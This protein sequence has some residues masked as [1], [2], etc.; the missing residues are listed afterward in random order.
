MKVARTMDAVPARGRRPWLPS[1]RAW[2]AWASFAI[3]YRPQSI[4][5]EAPW[6]VATGA[7]VFALIVARTPSAW[8]TVRGEEG[9][10][11]LDSAINHGFRSFGHFYSGY[12]DTVPRIG[13]AVAAALPL[14]WAA[15]VTATFTVLI[16][17]ICA[18][19]VVVLSGTHL[20]S[21]WVRVGLGLSFALL[22]ASR[23]PSIS[24]IQCLQFPMTFTVFWVLLWR[25]RRWAGQAFGVV[26]VVLA[27][28]SSLL[29]L[30]LAPLALARLLVRKGW[31]IGGS[32][33]G[34]LAF[35]ELLILVFRPKRVLQS[36]T[37]GLAVKGYGFDVLRSQLFGGP[38]NGAAR[39]AIHFEWWIVALILLVVGAV[40]AILVST[41]A[42][43]RSHYVALI[44]TALVAS[45]V[46]FVGETLES[47][48]DARYA[49]VP[50][51]LLT[52]AVAAAT[53]C[54]GRLSRRW[55]SNV[56]Q[57]LFVVA[58]VIPWIWSFSVGPNFANGPRWT[59]SISA[60]KRQCAALGKAA[61]VQIETLP[62][63]TDNVWHVDVPCRMI[64]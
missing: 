45:F 55:S 48:K 54:A 47:G 12:L 44:V 13:G 38:F 64:R 20:R 24:I 23:R 39:E 4:S 50:A 31:V 35:H 63:T 16:V 43:Q 27:A 41:P 10:I 7:A 53:D 61:S 15:V 40:I 5:G 29:P 21:R 32:F 56:G 18:G 25:P 58:V 17:A 9:A 36:G 30:V 51:L 26:F 6:A 2:R 52:T 59:P 46:L 22:P 1:P 37:L 28:L 14:R 33:L 3:R 60:G 11:F 8:T 19:A 49:I 42:P 34:A 62:L 57:S